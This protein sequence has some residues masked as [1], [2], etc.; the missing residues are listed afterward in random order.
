ML[1]VD[2]DDQAWCEAALEE[3]YVATVPGSA[4]NAPGYARISYAASEE[5]LR[6]AV[7]RLVSDGFL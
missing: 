4:F 7:D 1:P 6:E 3:S 2:N 5:R